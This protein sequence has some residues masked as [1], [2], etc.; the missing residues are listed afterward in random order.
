MSTILMWG[1]GFI[2]LIILL[3]K[4]PGV[5]YLV[6]PIIQL[7]TFL[8]ST[9]SENVG[10]WIVALIKSVWKAHSVMAVHLVKPRDELDPTERIKDANKRGGISSKE[11]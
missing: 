5:R 8:V 11:I 1:A 10:A 3:D 7:I 9:F 2:L 4:L 6:Q